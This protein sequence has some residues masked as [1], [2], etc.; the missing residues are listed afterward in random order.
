MTFENFKNEFYKA[1]LQDKF[2]DLGLEA[3]YDYI[4]GY[5][6][7]NYNGECVEL[8]VFEACRYFT[9]FQ[10]MKDFWKVYDKKKF[11]DMETIKR[12]TKVIPCDI[13]NEPFIIVNFKY[14]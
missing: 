9:E 14:E 10:S 13:G 5:Y 12:H 2:S 11:P 4:Y 6:E 8:S 7:D 1:R 3:L